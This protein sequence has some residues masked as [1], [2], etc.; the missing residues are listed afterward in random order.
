MYSKYSGYLR[1]FADGT[2]SINGCPATAASTIP[3]RRLDWTGGNRCLLYL[4]QLKLLLSR[5]CCGLCPP[6]R[7]VML[8]SSLTQLNSSKCRWQNL[9][10]KNDC[11]EREDSTILYLSLSDTKKKWSIHFTGCHTSEIHHSAVSWDKKTLSFE[12][13]Q[14][15]FRRV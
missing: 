9:S 11:L 13:K 8:S 2:V 1:G 15:S 5:R 6:C 12:D 10:R 4:P 7:Q 14:T 3:S